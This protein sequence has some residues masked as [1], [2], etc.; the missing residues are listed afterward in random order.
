VVVQ[1]ISPLIWRR[2]L[3][4]SDMSPAVLH[5]VLQI[6]FAWSDVHLHG[7]R[8]H[9]K[10]YGRTLAEERDT[11]PLTALLSGSAGLKDVITAPGL[12]D[13]G[14][15][16][17]VTVDTGAGFDHISVAAMLIPTNDCFLPST[18]LKGLEGLNCFPSSLLPTMPAAK[19]TM[20]CVRPFQ[21]QTL[22]NVV[23]PEGADR[24]LGVK[25]DT[26]IFLPGFT[27]LGTCRQ[28]SGIGETLWRRS[29]SRGVS[30][31]LQHGDY[32]KEL[33]STRSATRS[34]WRCTVD[35]PLHHRGSS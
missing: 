17:T 26:S 12:L 29:R 1:G 19:S 30:S 8:I 4:R 31:R 10:E 6:I 35:A 32:H 11:G 13:P 28:R 21:G 18:A 15:S 3:V 2:L 7:F 34:R 33:P 23:G 24:P 22:Q 5:D 14:A 25:K 20:N 9:G 27:V 16:V